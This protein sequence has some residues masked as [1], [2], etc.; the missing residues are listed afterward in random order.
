MPPRARSFGPRG[1]R[2]WADLTAVSTLDP[3][4]A[5]IAEEACRIADRLDKLDRL[6]TGRDEEWLRF[7]E[8]HSD[9][10]TVTV[11]VDNL[12]AEA[13]QQATALRGLVAQLEKGRPVAEAEKP[14]ASRSDDLAARRA[15]RLAGAA[16]S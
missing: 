13:R 15:A 4:S 7:R 12:L 2:L 3:A 11:V 5:V 9:E 6:I 10:P 16:A 1:R 14:E 8:D